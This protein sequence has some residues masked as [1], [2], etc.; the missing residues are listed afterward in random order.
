MTVGTAG[1]LVLLTALLC[2][3]ACLQKPHAEQT[4]VSSDRFSA[5]GRVEGL[6]D[7]VDVS[8]AVSGRIERVLVD[9]GD[10]VAAGRAAGRTRLPAAP[11]GSGAPGGGARSRASQPDQAPPRIPNRGA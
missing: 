11:R 8:A 6:S 1:R 3:A 10:V 7:A 2:P 5:Q 9:E 4:A